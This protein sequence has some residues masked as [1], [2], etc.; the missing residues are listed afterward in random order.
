M[1]NGEKPRVRVTADGRGHG[2]GRIEAPAVSAVE[3]DPAM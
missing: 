2:G 1:M 3:A